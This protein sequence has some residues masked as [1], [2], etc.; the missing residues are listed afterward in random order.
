MIYHPSQH[1]YGCDSVGCGWLVNTERLIRGFHFAAFLAPTE[2]PSPDMHTFAGSFHLAN[3]HL[4]FDVSCS[5][6]LSMFQQCHG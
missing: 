1:K 5:V 6:L 3:L 4:Q 2:I